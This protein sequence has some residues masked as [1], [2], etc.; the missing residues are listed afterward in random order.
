MISILFFRSFIYCNPIFTFRLNRLPEICFTISSKHDSWNRQKKSCWLGGTRA[1]LFLSFFFF[2]LPLPQGT[3]IEGD[4]Q[5]SY[6]PMGA[7]LS[8][9]EDFASVTKIKYEREKRAT[10]RITSPTNKKKTKL[11][12]CQGKQ[13]LKSSRSRFV[14]WTESKSRPF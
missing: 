1:H 2:L 10:N 9:Y 8:T 11:L 3:Y 5:Q 7:S 4:G 6:A 12:D 13:I 14:V